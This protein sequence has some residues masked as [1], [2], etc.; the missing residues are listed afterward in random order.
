MIKKLVAFSIIFLYFFSLFTF[1]GERVL[2]VNSWRLYLFSILNLASLT[3]IYFDFEMNLEFRKVVKSKISIIIG[4]YFLWALASYL[5]AINPTEVLIRS[6][7][8]INFYITFVVFWVFIRFLNITHYQIAVFFLISSIIQ[9]YPSYSNYLKIIQVEPYN[10][11]FNKEIMGFYFNRNI[12]A[13][14][15]LLHLQFVIYLFTK[16][17]NS[18]IKAITFIVSFLILYIV[19]ILASRTAILSVIIMCSFYFASY[20]YERKKFKD[21]VKSQFGIS[22]ITLILALTLSITNLGTS[23]DANPVNRLNSISVDE[24]STNG[25]LRYYAQSKDLFLEN[26]ILGLGLG[27][28]KIKSVDTDKENILSY[29][30]PYTVHNDFLENAV[31]LGLLGLILFSLIFILPVFR[32]LKNYNEDQNSFSLCLL[33]IM[34]IYLIDS[35]LNFPAIRAS[36]LFYLAIFINLVYYDVKS[37][38]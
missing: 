25:R 36:Q 33:L 14:N 7:Y 26:P 16:T 22:I 37:K 29:I 3:F 5:Y 8:I 28:W 2:D 35:N 31:E 17:K 21:I 24:Q 6:T 38:I 10:N 30:I 34:I 11:N 20:L 18:L 27:G 9:I 4:L 19:F 13:I 1:P 12:T 23:S 15:Y 32:I